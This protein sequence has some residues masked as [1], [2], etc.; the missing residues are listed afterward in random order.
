MSLQHKL[1]TNKKLHLNSLL[2][3]FNLTVEC[4]AEKNKLNT[5]YRLE[6]FDYGKVEEPLR[7]KLVLIRDKPNPIEFE[8]M[9]RASTAALFQCHSAVHEW[10]NRAYIPNS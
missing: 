5:N 4:V 3:T 2:A 8:E 9:N 10:Q 1:K 7:P 6:Q